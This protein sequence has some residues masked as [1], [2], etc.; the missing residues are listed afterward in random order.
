MDKTYNEYTGNLIIDSW[1]E[2]KGMIDTRERWELLKWEIQNHTIKYSKKKAKVR[3]ELERKVTRQL[4]NL[5]K[6]QC[7]AQLSS[8]QVKERLELQN[9]LE[10]IFAYR[11]RG[12]QIRSRVEFIEYNEKS[13][14]FF[15]NQEKQQFTRKTITKLIVDDT[16]VTKEKDILNE[17]GA[18]YKSLFA[19]K[20]TEDPNFDSIE[21]INNLPKLFENDKKACDRELSSIE[22]KF[23]LTSMN[24]NKSPG[25]DGLTVEFYIK[26]WDA[27]EGKLME[28]FKTIR[29][30]GEL[31]TSQKRGVISLLAKKGRNEAY[32]KNWRP[33]SLL[34]IDYK[35]LTKTLAKRI[36]SVIPSLIHTDQRGFIKGRYIGENIRQVQD[37]MEESQ[38]RHK[39]GLMLLL[40]FEKAFDS[41]EWPFM[42]YCLKKFNFGEEFIE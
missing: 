34:N 27:L 32:I 7:S 9:I 20:Y 4:D 19:S 31:S 37:V 21:E 16:I 35:I 14:K 18:F 17:L 6:I 41:I 29:A 10:N 1:E 11:E 39:T 33:I 2:T 5:H 12:A 13:N 15:Y 22:C 3:Q 25:S 8:E 23:A 36:S 30:I 38:I 24:R 26:F 28:T 42:M 40:D